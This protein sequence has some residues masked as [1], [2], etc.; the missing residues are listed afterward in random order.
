[1]VYRFPN[2][3]TSD[4]FLCIAFQRGTRTDAP[5]AIILSSVLPV[6]HN[7]YVWLG[8]SA[9]VKQIV[10]VSVR[11]FPSRTNNYHGLFVLEYFPTLDCL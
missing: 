10:S 1:M 6:P 9:Q 4:P 11:I 5:R 8:M 3:G 2:P 7:K